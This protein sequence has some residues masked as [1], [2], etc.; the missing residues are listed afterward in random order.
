[1][2]VLVACEYSGI[3]REAFSKAGHDA[4]SVDLLETEKPGNHIIGN[5][6]DVL[7]KGWDLLIGFPPCTYLSNA[8]VCFLNKPGRMEKVEKAAQFFLALYNAPIKKIALENPV[9]HWAAKRL[10]D[11][12]YSQIIEPYYFGHE[13]K[14]RTCLWLK[15][16][17]SLEP[18]KIVEPAYHHVLASY[19]GE[20]RWKMRSRTFEGVAKAMAEQWTSPRKYYQIS[21]F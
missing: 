19:A 11:V 9:Q 1:M 16:L 7:G 18:T 20:K 14:K 4:W 15:N 3:V 10:I 2:R 13:A 12:Q 21:M 17:P 5:V 6:L 8:G